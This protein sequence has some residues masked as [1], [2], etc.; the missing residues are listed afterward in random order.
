[1]VALA[2]HGLP[3][4]FDQ[5]RGMTLDEVSALGDALEEHAIAQQQ[6]EA[7]AELRQRLQANKRGRR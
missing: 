2:T 1:M 5:V 4:T 6:A 7:M 3:Y